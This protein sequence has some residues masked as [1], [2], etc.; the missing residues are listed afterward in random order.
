MKDNPMKSVLTWVIGIAS[1]AFVLL[2]MVIIFGNLSQN[3][4][5]QDETKTIQVTNESFSPIVFANNTGYSF[6]ARN[7]ST[8]GFTVLS[9]V[10]DW[11]QSNGSASSI[12]ATPTGYNRTI[13]AA[14]YT[15]N[16]TGYFKNATSYVF[17][18]GSLTY[19]YIY[20]Y[21]GT[22]EVNAENIIGNYTRGAVNTAVQFPVV[23]TILGVA[24]LILILLA[25]LVFVI[26]R[27]SGVGSGSGGKGISRGTE[28][29]G[30]GNFG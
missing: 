24:I 17:P 25:L 6:A 22:A 27:M 30:G 21:N 29:D 11:N 26:L 20:S 16:S 19:T 1:V 5:F 15:I 12:A 13:A 3:V 28:F 8:S 23:G 18:N 14:N 9:F 4:G 10:A 2:L 7:A